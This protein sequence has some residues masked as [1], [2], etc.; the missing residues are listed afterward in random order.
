MGKGEVAS[1]CEGDGGIPQ[2]ASAEGEGKE[3][4]WGR[5][6]VEAT[7]CEASWGVGN[8]RDASGGVE[9][10][11]REEEAKAEAKDGSQ[12]APEGASCRNPLRPNRTPPV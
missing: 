6:K 11:E 12:G 8:P 4:G 3:V 9:E 10:K 1:A 2:G 7:L 5:R